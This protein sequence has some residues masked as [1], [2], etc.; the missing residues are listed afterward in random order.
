VCQHDTGL[1]GALGT[2]YPNIVVMSAGGYGNI[3]IPL[4]GKE[5]AWQASPANWTWDV[6][7]WG[8]P[9]THPTR[10]AIMQEMRTVLMKQK[11]LACEFG[12]SS[13]WEDHMSQTKLNLAP[14][15]FGRTSFRLSEI[16]QMG[17]IPVYLYAKLAWIPYSG[18]SAD[19]RRIAFVG[20]QLELD[21]LGDKLAIAASNSTF[22]E[23]ALQHIVEHRELFTYNG[24]LKQISQ[25]FQDPLGPQGG[26]LRCERFPENPNSD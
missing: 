8:K 23:S 22:V 16:I 2:D 20:G 12:R 6:S 17:R 19:L 10:T 9:S 13:D 4:L 24:V 5:L 3:P 18:T 11:S 25:F 1:F 14:R 15:G 7:F 21:D 26:F